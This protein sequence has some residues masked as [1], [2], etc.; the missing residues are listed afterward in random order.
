MA[1]IQKPK[2]YPEKLI[3][4]GKVTISLPIDEDIEEDKIT[5]RMPVFYNETMTL[6]RDLTILMTKIFAELEGREVEFFDSMAASGIR[7]IRLLRELDCVK[8]V[9]IKSNLMQ[10]NLEAGK[11]TI[12]S[13]DARSLLHR[14]RRLRAR[15]EDSEDIFCDIIDLDPFGTPSPYIPPAFNSI[16]IGG[17]LCVTA[18]DTPVLFGIRKKQCV[19]KYITR[20][21][22]TDYLKELG[23]RILIYYIMKIA[24]IHEL[25]IEPLLSISSDH[26]VRVY[27]KIHRG[28]GG[29]NRNL[30]QCGS[31][32]HCNECGYRT[33]EKFNAKKSKPI[34]P[35]CPNC[36]SELIISGLNWLGKLHNKSYQTKLHEK[37]ES[38]DYSYLP[39]IRRIKKYIALSKEENDFPPYYFVIPRIA[40]LISTRFPD[41][42]T[43]MR[44]LTEKGYSA[45]RTHFEPN[46]IKTNADITIIKGILKAF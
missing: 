16:K 41:F 39:S 9:F 43:I 19:R 6:N 36:G 37:V 14:F 34:E 2:A 31:Y 15:K 26:F 7:T 17:M 27:L 1:K 12:F 32:I 30:D 24:H 23:T 5:K 28:I 33:T 8:H 42:D 44:E 11:Y 29:V 3:S 40:G 38:P 21:S 35:Q 20:P 4:E 18:T 22:K 46:A 25:Y 10:N 13:E 45:S